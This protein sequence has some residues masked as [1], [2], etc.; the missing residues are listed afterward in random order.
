MNLRIR[1]NLV[2]WLHRG[3]AAAGKIRPAPLAEIQRDGFQRIL[4]VATT[5]IG[6]AVLCAPLID[7]LR[8]A[9]PR[10]RIGFW[11]SAA[12][13]PLFDGRDGLDSVLPYH[14][15]YRRVRQT[16]ERLRR[17]RYDLALVANANDP[18]V[19]PMIWWSGCKRII[20]RPQRNTIYSFMIANPEMLSVSHISGHAIARNLE[21]CDLLRI[22]RGEART[23][24]EVKPETG[25]RVRSLIGEAPQPWWCIHPGSSRPEKQWDAARYAELARRILGKFPGTLLITGAH[26]EKAICDQVERETGGG[27]RVRNLAAQ[28][29]LD[30]LAALLKEV[31]LLISG[32]T[33]PYHI[34]MALGAP[35]VTLFAPWDAGSSAAINGPYF[36]RE[37]HRVVE[38]AHLGDPISTIQADQVFDACALFLPDCPIQ[39]KL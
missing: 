9:C 33:G 20:R 26:H 37:I 30:E 7:S 4:V 1:D 36:D 15:K 14:G 13:V 29:R 34:A 10:A 25:L 2:Y 16:I 31:G 18:D 21:F 17:E 28:F 23:C 32:D 38:T 24:L 5:A 35:T 27:G 19:I 11:V 8:E 6:D 12:A 3:M 39:P 22:P